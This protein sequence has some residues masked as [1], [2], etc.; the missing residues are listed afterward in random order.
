MAAP[1]TGPNDWKPS[2]TT[3]R[4]MDSSAVRY[5]EAP[6]WRDVPASIRGVTRTQYPVGA[7]T[8]AMRD[9]LVATF[10]RATTYMPGRSRT[11]L[12][13]QR[14]DQH[15]W[16]HALDYM[17]RDAELGTRIAEY[18]VANADSMGV[19]YVVFAGNRWSQGQPAGSRRFA[20]YEGTN[21][22][23]DHLHIELNSDGAAGRLPWYQEHPRPSE[24]QLIADA[25]PANGAP[26][27]GDDGPGWP[28]A[29]AV[30]IG[31]GAIVLGTV[32]VKAIG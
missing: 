25:S 8:R 21:K 10:G 27:L 15:Q 3:R 16:G 28:V 11:M 23:R 12:P 18:L 13:A 9:Y 2:E 22:H 31:V 1:L 19:Q 6:L 14:L 30:G 32:A 20:A 4:L 29:R 5:T 7:G 26:P 17:T 24:A